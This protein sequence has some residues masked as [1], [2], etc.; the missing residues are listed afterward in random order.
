MYMCV[1]LYVV[2]TSRYHKIIG[3]LV[4]VDLYAE[5]ESPLV[6]DVLLSAIKSGKIGNLT[7]SDEGFELHVVRGVLLC[8]VV[9]CFIC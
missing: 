1:Y 3:S 5:K 7:V 8:V 9:C 4:Y 6:S 2:V